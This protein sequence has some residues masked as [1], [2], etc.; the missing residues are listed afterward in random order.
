MIQN[1]DSTQLIPLIQEAMRI[2]VDHNVPNL[3]RE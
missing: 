1:M 3:F 2:F